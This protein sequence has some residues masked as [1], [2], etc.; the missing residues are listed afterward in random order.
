[1]QAEQHLNLDNLVRHGVALRLS[2][3]FFKE[4]NLLNAIEEIFANY[5]KYLNNAQALAQKLPKPEG[6]KNAA[7]RVVE[8][9]Q[10][11]RLT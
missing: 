4:K 3:T 8:I 10:Q 6:D 7:R 1:M 2:K 5:D 9:L 11:G